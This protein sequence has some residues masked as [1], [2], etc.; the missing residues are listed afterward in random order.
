MYSSV[1]ANSPQEAGQLAINYLMGEVTGLSEL[2]V[3]DIDE[4]SYRTGAVATNLF[5]YLKVPAMSRF[6]QGPKV[7]MQ[8]EDDSVK[9]IVQRVI[10]DM[11]SDFYY[12]IGPGTTTQAIMQT[13][14]L[15]CTLV[16]V[17]V[18]KEKNIIQL[19]VC[20]TLLI[21]LTSKGNCKILVTP[22]GGQAHLFGRGNQ[23]IS[24]V[25][26]KQVGI[27]NILIVAT[28]AK[29]ASLRGKSLRVDLNNREIEAQFPSYLKVITGYN[30]ITV[31]SIKH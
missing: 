29:L 7:P 16:G 26:I 3:I 6:I 25:V 24:D 14:G 20:E 8:S 13:L 9:A 19:D 28:P 22:I 11:D 18:I 2:E 4:E 12:I 5:G 21:D 30:D 10:Q 17:D 1:F 23:Q 31:Y 15:D 27:D